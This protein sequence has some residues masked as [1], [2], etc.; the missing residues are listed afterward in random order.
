MKRYLFDEFN[1]DMI[2]IVEN[3]QKIDP[4]KYDLYFTY[5]YSFVDELVKN[6]VPKH[7]RITGVTAHRKNKV[8]KRP[9]SQVGYV[10]AN[11]RLLKEQIKGLHNNVYYT[12]NGVD[13]DMFYK[14][15]EYD[16]LDRDHI[17]IGHVGKLSPMKGQKE[18]IEPVIEKLK[19][20][21]NKVNYFPHYNT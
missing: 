15:N 17:N 16:L 5:G 13:T 4:K 19:K 14:K 10:H 6:K 7:K 20:R 12:P 1:I 3:S 8:L 2:N 18:V 11:S 9:L 21:G